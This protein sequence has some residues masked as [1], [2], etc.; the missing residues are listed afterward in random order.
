LETPAG[1]N[2]IAGDCSWDVIIAGVRHHADAQGGAIR[3]D[4]H[5]WADLLE[6][7]AELEQL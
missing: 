2:E 7:L 3:A 6:G 4:L 5:T 1:D